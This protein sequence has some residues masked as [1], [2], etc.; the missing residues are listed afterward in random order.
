MLKRLKTRARAGA[1][2][3]AIAAY[4]GMLVGAVLVFLVIRSYGEVLPAPAGS[5]GPAAAVTAASGTI[6][7]ADALFHVL[8]ALAAVILV[9]R[10]LGVL[11]GAIGQPPVIGEVLGGI[12]LGP[13][14]LGH[15]APSISAVLL[16]VSVAPFLG[17]VAQLGVVLYMFL[18]GLD[19][20]DDV[21]RRR[22]Y[23]TVV[24]SHASIVA[25]F[26]LGSLLSLYLYPRLAPSNVPFT[27]FALFIG[28]A[29]S[30][31]AFPVLARILSDRRMAK[32][33]IGVAALTCAAA[34]DVTAWCLLAFVVGVA[35]ADGGAVVRVVALTLFFIALMFLVVRPVVR[36]WISS[37]ERHAPA[38][39]DLAV[40][41]VGLLIAALATEEIGIHA[42][43]GAF[44]FGAVIP[45]DS[46]LARKLT[47]RLHDLV[48]ILFLPAF[49]AFAGMRTE[50]GLVSGIYEW[51]VCG[52]IIVVATFGKF[53]GTLI[54]ARLT[55]M[56]WRAAASLG[57]LMNTRG[58]MELIV[59]NVGLDLGA[60]SPKLFAMLVIMAL[61][62]TVGTSPLLQ[63][64][65]GGSSL[66]PA[67]RPVRAANP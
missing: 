32:T 62:T 49:F 57:I 37:R 61:A 15:I 13:S 30:I 44:L 9:G 41:L 66:E 46:V 63:F 59:L 22:T 4:A 53:G 11:L 34:G 1:R 7:P 8:L 2:P 51:L 14:L 38:R 43:F 55:G 67:E 21:F 25:P 64:L 31:T 39:E 18:V 60:I 27:S 12:L 52:L 35:K 16:P 28:V 58:L 40:V 36:W 54:A 23:A 65:G 6:A 20:N 24:T 5:G 33:E 42:L 48:T 19:L 17:V 47:E 56:R 50:I 10:L 26:V 45:H 3:G 29:M